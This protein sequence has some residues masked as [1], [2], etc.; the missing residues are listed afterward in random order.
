MKIEDVFE[1]FS[2]YQGDLNKVLD[3]L[4]PTMK[5]Q[6]LIKMY[7]MLKADLEKRQKKTKGVPDELPILYTIPEAAKIW[8]VTE[9]TVRNWISG[10][11]I[12]YR[13]I[14]GSI[15]FSWEDLMGFIQKFNRNLATCLQD[16]IYVDKETQEVV[17]FEKD[18]IY[19][20]ISENKV[21][22]TL[23]S[24]KW[25]QSA[26]FSRKRFEKFFRNSEDW[27]IDQIKFNLNVLS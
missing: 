10:G 9:Q 15:R 11:D 5:D 27:E 13:Q 23:F 1:E 17:P 4:N 7:Q 3:R 24:V 20:I 22:I 8:R 18:K 19:K 2:G 16:S 6:I 12:N 26:R 21:W 25:E 14:G